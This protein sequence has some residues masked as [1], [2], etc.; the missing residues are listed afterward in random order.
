MED[1]DRATGYDFE[2]ILKTLYESMGYSVEQTKLTGD[3]G[4]DLVLVKFG[5][6]VVVQAKRHVGKIGN[7][8]VQE[9]V[10]AV[11]HYNA[12]KGMVVTNSFF[13]PAAVAAA[14]SNR[15]DLIDRDS[16]DRLVKK[17]L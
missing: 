13:T 6:R 9:I 16:L 14:R 11:N 12:V 8:A 2:R 10:A 4:A 15:I 1:I 3:Q 7:K 5:E 17:H